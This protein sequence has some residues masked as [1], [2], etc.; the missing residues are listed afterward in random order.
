MLPGS[1]LAK[2][3]AASA[4]LRYTKL[5]VTASASECSW[6]SLRSAPARTPRVSGL[7]SEVIATAESIDRGE[8]EVELV[9]RKPRLGPALPV[10]AAG[11]HGREIRLGHVAR[12]VNAVEAR[13]VEA[14][15]RGIERAH[16]LDERLEVLV[17][18]S[19]RADERG[20]F[21]LGA[22]GG[23]EL[24]ARGHV[25]AI[26]VREAHGRRGRGEEDLARAALAR[27]LHDLAARRPAHD[28]VV[29]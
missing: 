3:R 27:H 25:D 15:D 23:D 4:A 9:A 10:A 1:S 14:L 29:H 6:K 5:V 21:G 20:D 22:S 16:R 7:C 2:R 13:A 11:F 24:G 12:D 8:A 26:D 28:R 18:D 17:H 19:V